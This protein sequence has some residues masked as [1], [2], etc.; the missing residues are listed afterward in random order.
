[1]HFSQEYQGGIHELI[2]ITSGN[3][4]NVHAKRKKRNINVKFQKIF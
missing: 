4:K 1:M 2:F 3:R